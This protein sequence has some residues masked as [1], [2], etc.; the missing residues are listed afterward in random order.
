VTIEVK[1][2][3]LAESISEA[4]LVEWLKADGAAVRADEPIATLETDKAAVE[5]V[6]DGAGVL[7][8]A[9]KPG[10]V[11][12]V[13]DVLARIAPGGAPAATTEAPAAAAPAVTPPVAAPAPAPAAPAPT[14]E[15]VL[16]PAVRR[17]VE[18]RGL[19][20]AAIAGTG[21]HGRV[22][23]EDA[24][25]AAPAAPAQPTAPAPASAA[26]SAA[27]AD[28]DEDVRVVPMNRIRQR[29]A[30]RLVQAQH[31]AA[32]LTTFNEIDMSRVM[33]LRARHKDAFEKSHGVK[34]GFMS[35]FARACVL[36]LADVPAVNAEIRG[37]DMVFHNRVHMGI[38]AS[39]PKG[40]VVPVVQ[41]AEQL[42][43]AGLEK[44]IA[45]LAQRAR[46]GVLTPQELS[47]GT[48]T[49]TNGGVFGSLLST[50]ILNPPQ[51]GILGMHKIEKRAVV[52][53]DDSIVV[54]PMMYVALSYD[55][56][57]IDGQQAVTFLVRVK[58]RLE[59]LERM[60]LRV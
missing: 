48:F 12:K 26:P 21:P 8:H 37:T 16:S 30:E 57:I 13:G 20:P 36:A 45:R 9:R 51:S 1:V 58:E 44:E 32:I 22:L 15:A 17:I 52:L 60:L 54:R 35:F 42:D 47:G 33:D 5:I 59:D 14:R 39:T 6:A 50:P 31:T 55:H 25:A 2:P 43:F 40:L 29:I 23:K 24:L 11:V 38:A 56:R 41:N 4:T 27:P 7:T 53:E 34:L 49:I 18:E 3:R 10:D 28:T 19:D 46:D